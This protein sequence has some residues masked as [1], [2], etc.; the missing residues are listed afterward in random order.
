MAIF[1]T[2][3]PKKKVIIAIEHKKKKQDG[4]VKGTNVLF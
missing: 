3:I 4:R 2:I 1:H